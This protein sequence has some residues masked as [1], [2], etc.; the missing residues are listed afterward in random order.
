MWPFCGYNEIQDPPRR[1]RII[2]LDSLVRLMGFT[3]F[4]S[5]HKRWIE[6]SL[7]VDELERKSHWTES[8][9]VGSKSFIEKIK[10]AL[11]SKQKAG[12]SQ[13]ARGIISLGK[14]S[15]IVA[16]LLCMGSDLMRGRMLK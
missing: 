4:Q 8:I 11:D 9:A 16:T 15:P 6:A 13:A 3:D 14:M 2:D 10:R 7:Q 1:Y 12:P 5:A